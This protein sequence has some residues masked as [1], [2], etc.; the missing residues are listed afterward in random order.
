MIKGVNK[1]VIEISGRDSLYFE[2]AVFYL[3]PGVS[4]IPA[5]I[6]NRAAGEYINNTGLSGR[7]LR[8]SLR[9]GRILICTAL[10]LTICVLL[11]I[12]TSAI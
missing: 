8:W 7:R 2:K 1:A 4:D 9:F 3:R 6:L 11:L 5:E 10:L 12:L